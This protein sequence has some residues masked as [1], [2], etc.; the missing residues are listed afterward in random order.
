MAATLDKFE[1]KE[2]WLPD[3]AGINRNGFVDLK[4]K[5]NELKIAEI[6]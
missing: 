2:K 6:E 4:S 3:V 1:N 5:K